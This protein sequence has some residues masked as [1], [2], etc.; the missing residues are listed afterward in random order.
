LYASFMLVAGKLTAA[1]VA[2]AVKGSASRLVLHRKVDGEG[3]KGED[4][5]DDDAHDETD[6]ETYDAGLR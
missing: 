5:T 4:E 2:D 1:G 6:N 3:D